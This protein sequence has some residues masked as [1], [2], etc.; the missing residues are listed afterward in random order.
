[1]PAFRLNCART[2][3]LD[4]LPA[5][6]LVEI[7]TH[8]DLDDLGRLACTSSIW[9]RWCG[10]VVNKRVRQGNLLKAVATQDTIFLRAWLHC[11]GAPSQNY[12][13][14]NI[15]ARQPLVDAVVVS[16]S[17]WDFLHSRVVAVR[18]L[19]K[20]FGTHTSVVDVAHRHA[21]LEAQLLCFIHHQDVQAAQILLAH[22]SAIRLCRNPGRT[23]LE[24]HVSSIVWHFPPG[25]GLSRCVMTWARNLACPCAQDLTLID[26]LFFH[27][28]GA[29]VPMLELMQVRTANHMRMHDLLLLHVDP[30]SFAGHFLF[31]DSFVHNIGYSALPGSPHPVG[32]PTAPPLIRLTSF[33]PAHTRTIHSVRSMDGSVYHATVL[34]DDP[35]QSTERHEEQSNIFY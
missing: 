35:N 34:I 20:F 25:D 7:L 13:Q 29:L 9:A 19:L 23:W 31:S 21:V 3:K 4:E 8:L 16:G 15:R 26:N 10:E 32:E 18:C 5:E 2:K 33:E 24:W 12:D 22:P 11:H 6:V 14:D 1:V 30:N 28:T 17:F 27:W